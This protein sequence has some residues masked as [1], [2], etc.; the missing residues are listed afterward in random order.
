MDAVQVVAGRVNNRY[1]RVLIVA[2]V[3]RIGKKGLFLSARVIDE[4]DALEVQETVFLVLALVF[5][6]VVADYP[7]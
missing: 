3:F 6:P 2:R 1:I 5:R 4:Y 7:Q